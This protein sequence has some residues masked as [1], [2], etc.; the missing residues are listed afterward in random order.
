MDY[1]FSVQDGGFH[2][3]DVECGGIFRDRSGWNAS[4]HSPGSR[5]PSS[6]GVKRGGLNFDISV[7]S[8]S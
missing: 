4:K 1:I 6:V 7:V 8:E 3:L 5:A 2:S